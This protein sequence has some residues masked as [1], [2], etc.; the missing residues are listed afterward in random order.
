M[1]NIVE[2]LE[3][4]RKT[5]RADTML[6]VAQ[7]LGVSQANI[8]NWKK[9]KTIPHKILLEYAERND[10]DIQWILEGKAKATKND[11]REDNYANDL[12][13][14]QKEIIRQKDLTIS[15][16]KNQIK[17]LK[18]T[19]LHIK[20][21]CDFRIITEL[22]T[23]DDLSYDDAWQDKK[24]IRGD[25]KVNGNTS[26]WGYTIE[27]VEKMSIEDFAMAYHPE[28]LKEAIKMKNLLRDTDNDM[29]HFRGLRTIKH[30]K[31][32]WVNFM[33]EYIFERNPAKGNNAWD[34]V[35]YFQLLNGDANS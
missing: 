8:T 20:P 25:M 28:S 15:D 11:S 29:V 12:I 14:A 22:Y 13:S 16:M 33:V 4:V 2:I 5:E 18:K 26:V 9:R 10:I 1:Y 6:K 32:H 24:L 27:E 19:S 3:R 30:K 31:G 35:S 7:A 23:D 34:A 21:A 17:S